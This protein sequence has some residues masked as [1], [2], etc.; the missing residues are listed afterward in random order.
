VSALAPPA[1]TPGAGAKLQPASHFAFVLLMAACATTIAPMGIAAALCGT[2]TLAAL[3]R[4]RRP[5]PATPVNLPGLA[6]FAALLVVSLCALDR[7]AS[8]PRIT[9]G[10]FPLLVGL[11]A[12][13]ARDRRTAERALAVWL[14]ACAL[15][16]VAGLVLWAMHGASFENRAR[17]LVGH[18]MTFAGQLTLVLPVAIAIALCERRPRWR[19]GATATAVLAL[20]ALAATFTRSAWIGLFVECG[21]LAGAVWPLGLLALAVLGGAAFA[22]APGA[23][24]ERLWSIFDPHHPTNQQRMYMWDAGVR[25]FRA[26]PLTGVG[27]QDLHALYDQYRAPAATEHAGH[28]HNVFV[29]IA[30]QM[31]VLGLATFAWLYAALVR[32]AAAGLRPQLKARGLAAGVRLGVVAAL[33]GFI[34][35][36]LFEWNFGSEVLLYPLYSLV[37]IAWAARAWD[38]GT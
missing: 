31:G 34:V 16:A 8:L 17:G 19:W 22:F 25:M 18:Y 38:A 13:H 15:A 20:A 9:K 28:L 12:F 3:A 35:A 14:G 27:L 6:W 30:A 32:A 1:A 33:A 11:A 7:A 24:H 29:Q 37:G 10:M 4:A 36:G 21:V 23:Y 2:L 26:H 5:W